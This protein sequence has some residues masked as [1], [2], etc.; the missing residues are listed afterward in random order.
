MMGAGTAA[1]FS[2][3]NGDGR[4]DLYAANGYGLPSFFYI[5]NGTGFDDRTNKAGVGEHEDAEGAVFGDYDNDGDMDLYV[6]NFASVEFAPLP[7][8]LYRNDGK[9][10][11]EDVTAEAGVGIEDYSLGAAFGD[12]DNDG[13]LDLYVVI[14]GG[15]NILYRNN[16]DG[17]FTDVTSEAGVG[18]VGFGS[19][20]ALGDIDNDGYLDIYVANAGY[21][22]EDNPDV[23][24]LNNGGANHWLQVQ[25]R[26]ATGSYAGLGARISVSAGELHQVREI[27]GVRGYGQNSSIANFG[28]ANTD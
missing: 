22:D 11:F 26:S 13:H 2:D 25:L 18:D 17:T 27:S 12:L 9:D 23:L 6:T 19:N 4:L 16:G 14:N 24:Y 5:N 21:P 7:D 28:L 3:S 10:V 20:A 1:V 15:P 8:V